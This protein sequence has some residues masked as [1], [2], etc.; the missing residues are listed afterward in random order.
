MRTR[1]SALS[2]ASLRVRKVLV[3]MRRPLAVAT[4][5]VKMAPLVLV[6]IETDAERRGA[7]TYSC[8]RR[9]RSNPLQTS[10]RITA[11]SF[12]DRGLRRSISKRRCRAVCACSE[13]KESR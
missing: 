8:T 11:R 3:P 7:R 5:E 4:G 2:V 1:E 6:D 9:L 10:W 12:E 13:R